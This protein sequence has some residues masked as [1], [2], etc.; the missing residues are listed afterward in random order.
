MSENSTSHAGSRNRRLKSIA[1]GVVAAVAAVSMCRPIAFYL[2]AV[3]NEG[4][5]LTE[6]GSKLL[7]KAPKTDLEFVEMA[8]EFLQEIGWWENAPILRRFHRSATCSEIQLSPK[9]SLGFLRLK[10]ET[11]LTS[12][13][14]AASLE[15]EGGNG[16]LDYALYDQ[17]LEN[18][19]SATPLD[20]SK[21]QID[22]SEILE[23]VEQ[24][25]G[26]IF[27]AT[28]GNQCLV[29]MGIVPGDEFWSVDYIDESYK[30]LLCFMV[31]AQTG[32]V[33]QIAESSLLPCKYYDG[34]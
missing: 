32:E 26:E 18:I 9:I 20:I 24:S 2:G 33:H 22:S 28:I 1:I 14:Y 19:T 16:R 25:G 13:R 27:R 34:S 31:H 10:R 3:T 23:R 8:V 21:L 6:E 17:G 7:H 15:I 11:L 30:P 29:R 12:H 4:R 5:P